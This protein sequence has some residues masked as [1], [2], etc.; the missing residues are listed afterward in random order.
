MHTGI[1]I[2]LVILPN[3][4]QYCSNNETG[5]Y[6]EVGHKY[7]VWLVTEIIL[8]P[9]KV[10]TLY[11]FCNIWS[12]WPADIVKKSPVLLLT[13]SGRLGVVRVGPAVIE[14][15]S[16]HNKRVLVVHTT[17]LVVDH[18]A[19]LVVDI[20]RL[21]V[22]ATAVTIVKVHSIWISRLLLCTPRLLS[23]L[24]LIVGSRT[25]VVVACLWSSVVLLNLTR[26]GLPRTT[27]KKDN[28]S[29]SW[30][31]SIVVIV[32]NLPWS[33]L[34]SIV[35]IVTNLS[36]SWLHSII[37]VVWYGRGRHTLTGGVHTLRTGGNLDWR[38]LLIVSWCN[39]I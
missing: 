4:L 22:A 13:A 17:S 12:F 29:W 24:L 11:F 10:V 36:W 35:V 9:K 27:L 18:T 6:H 23:C 15:W 14:F 26:P 32:A 31:Y 19:S 7:F 38:L 16:S 1:F 39:S 20:A 25:R 5:C 33:W 3:R 30:L 28:L 21:L 8:A 2:T 34:Y 37:Q